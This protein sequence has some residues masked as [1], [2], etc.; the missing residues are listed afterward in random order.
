M[1]R[2][3]VLSALLLSLQV[4]VGPGVTAAS[5]AG[6]TIEFLEGPTDGA[7]F[8]QG[9]TLE[10]V[11]GAKSSSPLSEI[12]L[13]V[14]PEGDG[15]VEYRSVERAITWPYDRQQ[16]V[17]DDI[18]A[19]E[20]FVK[21]LENKNFKIIATA[22]SGS[23]TASVARTITVGPR[24]THTATPEVGMRKIESAASSASGGGE[25]Y[26]ATDSDQ[27]AS[28]SGSDAESSGPSPVLLGGGA[29]VVLLV[30]VTLVWKRR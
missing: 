23:E 25:S 11:L 6:I 19:G 4:C 29:L 30:G 5:A 9:A 26:S 27:G 13:T 18:V 10:V 12:S 15:S 2:R 8:R 7:V 21:P 28:S 20:V 3:R 17:T 22:R 16:R 14:R 1:R 24:G